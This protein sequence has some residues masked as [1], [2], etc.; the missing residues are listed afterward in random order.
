MKQLYAALFILTLAFCSTRTEA[1]DIHFSQYFHN[2]VLVNPAF[3]GNHNGVFRATLNYRN[4]WVTIPTAGS[5][6]PYVTY[7]GSFDARLLPDRLGNDKFGIGVTMFSDRAGDGALTTQSAMFSIAYHK[8]TDRYGQNHLTLGLQ[9][10]IVSKRLDITKLLFEEQL[11]DFGFDPNA[12]NGE[13]NFNGG[14]M[15][16]ADVNVGALWQ[17]GVSENF[18]YYL[19]FSMH[20]VATPGE[21]F[22]QDADNNLSPRYIAQAGADIKL[23]RYASVSPTFLYMTQSN[24]QQFHVG[25]AF[26]Y[27]VNED[28]YWFAGVWTRVKDAV[29]V[30]TGFDYKG[31]KLGITYDVNISEFRGATNTVGAIELGLVYIFRNQNQRFYYEKYCPRF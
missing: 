20:H 30:G 6:S 5:S 21:S 28:F 19:G 25:A 27:D 15:F 16:Y 2:P 11:V 29:I 26:N 7:S 22:L 23:G 10:G 13:N 12:F 14:S 18:K 8:A 1:Q 3:T 31:L 4:Q 24:A 17:S 9:A